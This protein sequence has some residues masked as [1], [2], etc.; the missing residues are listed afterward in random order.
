MTKGAQQLDELYNQLLN[1]FDTD[2]PDLNLISPVVSRSPSANGTTS[3]ANGPPPRRTPVRKDTSDSEQ[4]LDLYQ[5]YVDNAEAPS[6]A[7]AAVTNN[8]SAHAVQNP[9]SNSPS[10]VAAVAAA[11]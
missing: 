5:S 11:L 1:S 2:G 3:S 6:A 4:L 7:A 8:D 9:L 10:V